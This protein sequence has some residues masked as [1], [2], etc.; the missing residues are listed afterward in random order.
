MPFL[1]VACAGE[2]E[3]PPSLIFVLSTPPFGQNAVS[4]RSLSIPQ[5]SPSPQHATLLYSHSSTHESRASD[6]HLTVLPIVPLPFFTPIYIVAIFACTPP[7]PPRMTTIPWFVCPE[8]PAWPRRLPASFLR[9]APPSAW[10]PHTDSAARA[11]LQPHHTGNR[12]GTWRYSVGTVSAG[13][14]SVWS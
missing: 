5:Q 1:T 11:A 14:R 12:E 9:R 3:T 8:P 4:S 6:E 2:G 7:P 10:R 13:S